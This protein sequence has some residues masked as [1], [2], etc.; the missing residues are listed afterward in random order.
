MPQ[1]IIWINVDPDECRHMLS[2][3]NDM[4][5]DELATAGTWAP[6]ARVMAQFTHNSLALAIESLNYAPV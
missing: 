2:P 1:V 5:A 3:V 4:A 6:V